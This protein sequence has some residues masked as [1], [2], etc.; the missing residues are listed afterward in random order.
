MTPTPT[1]HP[2]N[3][4]DAHEIP[5]PDIPIYVYIVSGLLIGS[6]LGTQLLGMWLTGFR[7]P[8]PI[9]AE[10][11]HGRGGKGGR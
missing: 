4:P 2:T 1:T 3:I 8:V 7:R 10:G 9:P 11:F 6:L 5:M